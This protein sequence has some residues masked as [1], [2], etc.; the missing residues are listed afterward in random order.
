[1]SPEHKEALAKG[2]TLGRSVKAYLDALENNR[3]KRGRKRTNESITARLQSLEQLITSADPIKR[4]ALIQE[5]I[6]LQSELENMAERVDLTELEAGF[7]ANAK[8]YSES[9]GIGYHAWRELGVSAPVLKR[10]GISRSAS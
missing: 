4:I 8:E 9:K 6:D 7:V 1:M 2:R 3:P 5:R 10:A